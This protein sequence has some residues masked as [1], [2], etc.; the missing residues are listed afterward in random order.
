MKDDLEGKRT[1][2][3]LMIPIRIM[4]NKR[5]KRWMGTRE[6]QVWAH[7]YESIIRSPKMTHKIS[8]FIFKEYFQNGI[9]AARWDQKKIAVA[10]GL[11]ENS[12]GYISRLL[13]SMEKKGVIKKHKKRWYTK[14]LKIYELGVHSGEPYKHES[15]HAITHFVQTDAEKTLEFFEGKISELSCEEDSEPS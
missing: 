5:F 11:S 8:R 1:E 13:S 3:F 2:P 14:N 15:L 9:L 6:F 10:L 12:D 7:L 4:K